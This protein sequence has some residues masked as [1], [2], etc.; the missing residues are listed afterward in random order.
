M[1]IPKE[2]II[3]F[4]EDLKLSINCRRNIMIEFYN[5]EF[6]QNLSCGFFPSSK[7]GFPHK[8]LRL[9]FVIYFR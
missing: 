6:I 2:N 4:G 8:S 9:V 7:Q 5:S 1:L 3:V